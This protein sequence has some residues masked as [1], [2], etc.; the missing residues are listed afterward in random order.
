MLSN[1]NHPSLIA[2]VLFSVLAAHGQT[3]PP[4]IT[5]WVKT[6]PFRVGGGV[7]APKAIYAPDPEYSEEARQA[8][9]QG[10]CILEL[11]VGPNGKP[12][13]IKVTQALGRGLDEK[14]I[15]AVK[16]WRFEP[17]KKYDKPVAT[18]INVEVAF[19]LHPNAMISDLQKKADAG[20]PKAELELSRAYLTGG[21]VS[22]KTRGL[23]LLQKA[24]NQ[25]LVQAQFLMGERAYA[26]SD[27]VKAYMWYE[28]ALRGG[29][30]QSKN[31]L[32]ELAHKM[33]PEQLSDAKTR[34]DNWPKAP[35]K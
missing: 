26:D 25:G 35:A 4:E 22:Q 6:T 17:G 23:E 19:R 21:D 10:T 31:I 12:R 16:T 24:A 7:S 11:V 27:Y 15:E 14:A 8:K 2:I 20:D 28:L 34:V 18:I 5:D 3:Q 33:S 32:K 9:L 30:T 29:Y 13:D 1:A